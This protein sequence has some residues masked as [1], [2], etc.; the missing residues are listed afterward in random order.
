MSSFARIQ[1]RSYQLDGVGWLTQC[2]QNQ[3]G[4]ILGDEMGLGKTCQGDKEKRAELKTDAEN[5]PFNVLL[6]TYEICIN[7]FSFLKR[8]AILKLVSVCIK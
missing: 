6:T 7:D 1:L 2:L 8:D 5:K 4:C 3:Q